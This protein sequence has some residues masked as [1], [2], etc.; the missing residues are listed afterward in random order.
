MIVCNHSLQQLEAN[1]ALH[2]EKVKS[3]SVK[4]MQLV[5]EGHFDSST[6]SKKIQ[7]LE[8]E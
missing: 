7:K 1:L 5:E 6:I 2:L 8:Q 4:A 3:L